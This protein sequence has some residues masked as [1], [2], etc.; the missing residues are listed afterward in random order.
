MELT[1]E[2]L[3]LFDFP[4]GHIILIL[5][6]RK[7]IKDGHQ[8]FVL[9]CVYQLPAL[10]YRTI[11]LSLSFLLCYVRWFQVL[12][13]PTSNNSECNLNQTILEDAVAGNPPDQNQVDEGD[14]ILRQF[15]KESFIS[16]IVPYELV[17]LK[18][19]CLNWQRV[20]NSG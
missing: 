9:L 17:N 12:V 6:L 10:S 4:M 20:V 15:V 11:C 5:K 18:S 16:T 14:A 13:D 3:K 1:P 2:T 7:L 8:V 19:R